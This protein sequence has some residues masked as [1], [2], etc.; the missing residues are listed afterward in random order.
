MQDYH[1]LSQFPSPLPTAKVANCYLPIIQCPGWQ[2]SLWMILWGSMG[3][4]KL[5]DTP[6]T[7]AAPQLLCSGPL[8]FLFRPWTAGHMFH[9]PSKVSDFFRIELKVLSKPSAYKKNTFLVKHHFF[10]HKPST[11]HPGTPLPWA[12]VPAHF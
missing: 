4:F 11:A 10:P 12:C 9:T 3:D 2:D 1:F 5:S 7:V 6:G 8:V